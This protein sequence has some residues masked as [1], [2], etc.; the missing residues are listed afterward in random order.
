MA[1]EISDEGM[2]YSI[3]DAG[4]IDYL[5]GE[6]NGKLNSH[7]ISDTKKITNR[8]KFKVHM[9]P[10]KSREKR[11]VEIG[12][13]IIWEGLLKCSWTKFSLSSFFSL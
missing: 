3:K 8:W 4:T 5:F 12:I 2:N 9:M 7:V 10:D 1:F 13:W 11:M 6:K